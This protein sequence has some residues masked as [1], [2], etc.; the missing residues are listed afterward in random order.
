MARQTGSEASDRVKQ[1][2][3]DWMDNE[4]PEE[5]RPLLWA[6]ILQDEELAAQWERYHLIGDV[7]RNRLSSTPA[8][9]VADRVGDRLGSEAGPAPRRRR[10][11]GIGGLAGGA[12]AASLIALV[13][14]A[15][16]QVPGMPGPELLTGSSQAS[17]EH[18]EPL[19]STPTVV[20]HSAPEAPSL[21]QNLDPRTRKRLRAYVADHNAELA[22][23][24][25]AGNL[26]YL[27]MT[28]SGTARER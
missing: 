3:S 10:F 15:A 14:L 17:V 5:E 1:Q 13:S 23:S 8:A 27:R 25:R 9:D 22:E 24:G 2:L 4:L 12:A 11:W 18:T 28:D 6:R 26:P 19:P 21:N 16:T 20:E 7:V